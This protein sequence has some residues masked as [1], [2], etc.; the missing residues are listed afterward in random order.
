MHPKF[1]NL[2]C[3]P[4]TGE[5]LSLDAL[6][7]LENGMVWAGTLRTESGRAYPIVRGVP[8]IEAGVV[9][10]CTLGERLVV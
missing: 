9:T 3:C 5:S 1:L 4:D 6:V 8:G 2:L 7:T 10:R